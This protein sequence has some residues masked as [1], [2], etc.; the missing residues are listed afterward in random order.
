[1]ADNEQRRLRAQCSHPAGSFVPFSTDD[2][3][4][5]VPV[6]FEQQVVRYAECLAIKS[7][8]RQHTYDALNRLANQIAYAILARLGSGEEPV[9]LLCEHDVPV[10]AALLGVLKAGKCYLPLDPLSPLARTAFM[11]ADSGARLIVTDTRNVSRAYEL[12][13]QQLDVLDIDALDQRLCT[14]NPGLSIPP[15]TLA[16]MYYTSGSTGQPKGVVASHRTRMVNAMR[17][18]NTLHICADDR[19]ILLYAAGFS[20]AVNATFGALLNGARLYPFDLRLEGVGSLARWLRSEDIT[21]Y[22]SPPPVFRNFVDT[23]AADETFPSL[24]VLLLASDS[25]FKTDIERYRR[26]FA[27]TCLLLNAWG[28]TEAPFFRPYFIDKTSVLPGPAVPAIGPA[29]EEDEIR[30]LDDAGTEVAPGNAGE[31][32]VTSR[33]LSPGY[34]RR[35]DLTHARFRP[36]GPATDERAYFTGDLGR[37]LP[38]GSI[39]HLGRKDFQIKVRG[40]RVELEESEAELRKLDTIKDVVVVGRPDERGD[41]QLVAYIVPAEV[42]PTVSSLRHALARTL[43]EYLIPSVFV[44]MPALPL[45]P[46]G[47]VN[48]LALPEPGKTRPALDV[49]LVTPQT[50]LERTLAEIWADVLGLDEWAYTIPSWNWAAIRYWRPRWYRA[51]SVPVP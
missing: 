13:S 48:R 1:M 45:T 41:Q 25:V 28:A 17:T 44:Q 23:L 5:S 2:I 31:I 50:P 39:A 22:H 27:D 26:H 18:T 46:N 24:R 43:P 7:K 42:A 40:Y 49:P 47:K 37:M 34:W 8:T 14:D 21:I 38:D 35:D 30:L 10:I 51:C 33:Y 20:G 9:A 4:Q 3:A 16:S 19:L 15:D 29:L 12:A 32:V 6:R 36:V 11:L